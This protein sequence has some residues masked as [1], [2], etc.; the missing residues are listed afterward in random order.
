MGE[1]D[2]EVLLVVSFPITGQWGTVEELQS[3]HDLEDVLDGVLGPHQLGACTGGGQGMGYQDIELAAPRARWEATWALV[4][5]KLAE[6][7]TLGR[8][9][10]EVYLDLDGDDPPRL[11]WPPAQDPPPP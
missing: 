9:T 11:L 5:S 7:G 3:R 1:P 6:L 8:A 2:D 4:R 10:V